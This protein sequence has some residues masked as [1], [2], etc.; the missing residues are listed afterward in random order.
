MRDYILIDQYTRHVEYFFKNESGQWTLEE[1][2][3]INDSFTIRSIKV[4]LSLDAIY[5]QIKGER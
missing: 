2:Q 1:F 5:Y 4:E 3:N